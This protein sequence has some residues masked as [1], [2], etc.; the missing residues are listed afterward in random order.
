[1]SNYLWHNVGEK[2]KEEIREQAKKIL[3]SF[4]KK[5]SAVGELKESS[6]ELSESERAEETEDIASME[7]RIM[8]E[9]AVDKNEDFIISEKKTW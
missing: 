9:N 4:S 1:M 6:I 5:L 2:E 3:D 7:R 8:F